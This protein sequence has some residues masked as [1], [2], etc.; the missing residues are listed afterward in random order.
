MKVSSNSYGTRL[1]FPKHFCSS[2]ETF[3][4]PFHGNMYNVYRSSYSQL[5]GKLVKTGVL[6]L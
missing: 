6:I 2:I 1:R 5:Y 4:R 3:L